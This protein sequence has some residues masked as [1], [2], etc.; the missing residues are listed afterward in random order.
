M[1][2]FPEELRAWGWNEES[3]SSSRRDEFKCAYCDRLLLD[4]YDSYRLW[5]TD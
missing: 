3:L 5:E 4:S 2:P 1:K